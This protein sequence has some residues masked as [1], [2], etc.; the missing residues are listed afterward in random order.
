MKIAFTLEIQKFAK[1]DSVPDKE[2]FWGY[3]F[4]LLLHEKHMFWPLFRSILAR[5]FW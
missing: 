3:F 1:L 4:Y 2:E 5:W